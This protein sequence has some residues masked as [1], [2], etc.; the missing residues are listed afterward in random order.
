MK[1]IICKL[2]QFFTKN[3]KLTTKKA[4]DEVQ[5]FQ[6]T[7][8]NI[9]L[10]RPR[11]YQADYDQVRCFSDFIW[12]SNDKKSIKNYEETIFKIPSNEDFFTELVID[13]TQKCIW[14]ISNFKSY[15]VYR[16]NSITEFN[17]TQFQKQID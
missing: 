8:F 16:N 3:E 10:T 17:I 2:T 1:R 6:T 5:I 11:V 4:L 13:T 14:A 15:P 7:H 12:I 9:D